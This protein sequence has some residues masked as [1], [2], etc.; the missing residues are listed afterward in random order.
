[1]ASCPTASSST[2]STAS[3]RSPS[4]TPNSATPSASAWSTS[5]VDAFDALE[6]DD[7]VGAVVVT[8]APPAFCAGADLSH[9]GGLPGGRAAPHLRGLPPRRPL[10]AAHHRRGQR[11]RRRRRHEH[12]PVLRRAP[13]RARAARFDTRFL[14]LGI[15]PGGGHTWMLRRIVGAAGHHGRRCLRRGARRPARPS[16]SGWSGAASPT[17]SCSR[18][19]QAMAAKAAAAPRELARRVKATIADMAT[20]D[21]HADAV[22]RELD[23]PAVVD[24]PA[25]LRRAAGR[26]PGPHQPR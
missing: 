14:Q 25:R 11:R 26:H 5:I 1:M 4:T 7:D 23:R 20:I 9:L 12:G 19:A 17:T 13:R 24:G 6:A 16:G 8:G 3:P 10:P 15:H 2:S 22:E 21:D 18:P